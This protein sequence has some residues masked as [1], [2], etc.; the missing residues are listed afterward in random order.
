MSDKNEGDAGQLGRSCWICGNPATTDEHKAKRADVAATLR[1]P[2]PSQPLFY[3]DDEKRNRRVGSTKSKLLTWEDMLCAKCNNELTQPDDRAWDKLRD[4]L[5]KRL[6]DAD[7][8]ET[9][10]VSLDEMFGAGAEEGMLGVHRFLLKLFGCQIVHQGLQGTPITEFAKA[11]RERGAHPRVYVKFGRFDNAGTKL[12]SMTQIAHEGIPWQKAGFIYEVNL[13]AAQ[14]LFVA[15][16]VECDGLDGAW[17]PGSTA[18]EL[19][20]SPLSTD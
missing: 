9:I 14:V 10:V 3:S 12:V 20:I 15:D 16:G 18:T 11:I 5:L 13:F 4:A 17:H 8:S 2:L 19:T 7:P 6:H 1:A